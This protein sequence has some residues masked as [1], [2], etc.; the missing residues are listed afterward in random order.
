MKKAAVKNDC[1]VIG[2]KT[3]QHTQYDMFTIIKYTFYWE[4]LQM[5]QLF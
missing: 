4:L 1:R 3:V 5:T 2:M